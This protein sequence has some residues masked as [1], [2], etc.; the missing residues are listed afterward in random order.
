MKSKVA[1]DGVSVRIKGRWLLSQAGAE[2]EKKMTMFRSKLAVTSIP[3]LQ[4][5]VVL[6]NT[7]EEGR[8]QAS[9]AVEAPVLDSGCLPPGL[10]TSTY[11]TRST[12]ELQLFWRTYW[13]HLA[14]K[15]S[16]WPVSD[17]HAVN[18]VPNHTS[19]RVG[20]CSGLSCSHTQQRSSTVDMEW[21]LTRRIFTEGIFRGLLFLFVLMGRAAR[22]ESGKWRGS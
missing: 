2:K 7:T 13:T 11:D 17:Q 3:T 19:Y 10:R 15:G 22:E 21:F 12:T 20:Q 6:A 14:A 18:Q 4:L 1:S 16:T 8:G 5:G 9:I